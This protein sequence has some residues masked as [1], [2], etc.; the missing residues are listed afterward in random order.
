[1]ARRAD[2]LRTAT[3]AERFTPPLVRDTVGRKPLFE[4]IARELRVPA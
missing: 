4:R 3:A 1:M 2:R